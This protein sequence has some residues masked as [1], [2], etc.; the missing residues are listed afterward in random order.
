MPQASLDLTH[1]LYDAS[2]HTS[3]AMA[4]ITLSPILLMA[5]DNGFLASYAVL[6]VFTREMTIIIMW[7]GQFLC[8]GLNLV[9]KRIVKEERPVDSVG[10]G[11][12]FPSSHSQYMAY[13]A[14][15]LILH[16]H[17]RHRFGSSGYWIVD[18]A[19][20]V[21]VHLALIGWAGV[22]A[23]SRYH[24]LYHSPPQILWGV[25]IGVAFGLS[26][27]LVTELIPM[28]NPNSVLGKARNFLLMN[29]VSSWLRLRDGWAVWADS[30]TEEQWQLWRREWGR[31]TKT[32][33][34]VN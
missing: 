24:L 7:A 13:F 29:P 4:L 17:F 20:R 8:E 2:S 22:V 34:H 28:R 31:R 19:F 18:Q 32:D 5:C 15:F 6:A 10:N 21:L 25:S 14:T 30:G 9:V 16:L 23:Y 26:F 1:V 27:Y 3:L 11:Y 33:L 12:G